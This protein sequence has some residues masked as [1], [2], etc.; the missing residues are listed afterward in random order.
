MNSDA[1]GFKRIAI[2][3]L[4]LIG[5][6]LCLALRRAFP[7]VVL[8]GVDK[9]EVV[10][11]ARDR[12]DHVFSP[13]KLQQSL[14]GVE[15]V[16]LAPPIGAILEYL[17]RVAAW[18]DRTA[19][20]TDVGS[21]KAVI[22]D[23]ARQVMADRGYFI[24]GHPMTGSERSGWRHANASLFENAAYVLTSV[25]PVP[26]KIHQDFADLLRG[27]G[28][29]V[30]EMKADVHDRLIAEVSHLPQLV[31]VA[32]MNYVGRADAEKEMRL[33]LAAGGLRDMTRIA[34]SPFH[35]W[36]DILLT[37]KAA[38]KKSLCEFREQIAVLEALVDGDALDTY[39]QQANETRRQIDE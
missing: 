34:E 9:H 11:Q 5:G 22:V 38:I 18:I 13:D 16:F 10:E 20:V 3:G 1:T 6:S 30:I 17:P 15:L 14:H 37:N 21:T 2:I 24:G 19:L 7:N 26:G 32:L 39:F 28:A 4:G 29:R 31:A 33:E 12:L 25:D 36:Q 23:V 8:V 35:V 27:L